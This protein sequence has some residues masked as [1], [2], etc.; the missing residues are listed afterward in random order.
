MPAIQAYAGPVVV[1][2]AYTAV[3]YG[4]ML[5]VVR[6]KYGLA[7]A[8][9]ARGET[10]DRYLGGDREMLAADRI[11][12]NMLEHM[13]LFL[14]LLWLNAVFVD[15]TWATAVGGVYTATRALYPLL[16]GRTVGRMTRQLVFVA[17]GPS[18]LALLALAVALGRALVA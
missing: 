14:A 8:A 16:H 1:T 3:Y 11:Q 15:V 4:T 6:V 10:F 9:R 13:P 5:N 12:L 18:Y 2:L 17:T 7:R